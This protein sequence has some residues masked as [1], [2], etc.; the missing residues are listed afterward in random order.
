[1][2]VPAS[3]KAGAPSPA[4]VS[5]DY[6]MRAPRALAVKPESRFV[7]RWTPEQWEMVMVDGQPVLVPQLSK[8]LLAEG[9]NGIPMPRKGGGMLEPRSA[10]QIEQDAVLKAQLNGWRIVEPDLLVEQKFCPPGVQAGPLR[11]VV[12]TLDGGDR[13]H[14]AFETHA[15]GLMGG[16]V[17]TYHREHLHRWLASRLEAGAFGEP[18]SHIVPALR[19]QVEATRREREARLSTVSPEIRASRLAP[20]DA[21]LA[22]LSKLEAAD[23]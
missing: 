5:V 20:L 13:W 10:E 23:A 22:A 1:M 19:A 8:L 7:Y 16:A 9:V 2:P 15:P 12:K 11:R 4:P 18:P 6:V 3:K 14:D 21:Q 17:V